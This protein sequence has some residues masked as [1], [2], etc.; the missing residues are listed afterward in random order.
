MAA[1][2][3]WILGGPNGAGK[4][5]L[6][7]N[8]GFQRYLARLSRGPIR[9]LNPDKIA[10][11]HY[12]L[13]PDL[14]RNEANLWAVQEVERALDRH[15]AQ[16]S[17]VLVETVLSSDKYFPYVDRARAAGFRVGLFYVGLDTPAQSLARVRI[18]VQSGGHDVPPEKVVARFYRSMDRAARLFPLLDRCFLISNTGDMPQVV[19]DYRPGNFQW[20]VAGA[21][22]DLQA[23]LMAACQPAT[24][25]PRLRL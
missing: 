11:S 10:D 4:T 12:A 1:P 5:T 6:A 23:R 20:H 7:E 2:W 24:R 8:P 19:A 18:R 21:L 9:Y 22:P 3:F 16:Q 25:Q 17:T 13:Y 15:F 14:S